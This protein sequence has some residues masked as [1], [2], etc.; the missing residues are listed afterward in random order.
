MLTIPFRWLLPLTTLSDFLCVKSEAAGTIASRAESVFYLNKD[1]VCIETDSKRPEWL[2][3]LV[4]A[5]WR[6]RKMHYRVQVWVGGVRIYVTGNWNRECS[7]GSIDQ[8]RSIL[9]VEN[10][11]CQFATITG[12]KIGQNFLRVDCTIRNEYCL[13][14]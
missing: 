14:Y 7:I 1:A 3:N 8:N 13:T 11:S 10:G 9:R 2:P 4:C 6:Y 12:M 5:A